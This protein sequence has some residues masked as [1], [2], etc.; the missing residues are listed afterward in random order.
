MKI[1]GMVAAL[2]ITAMSIS[3]LAACGSGDNQSQEKPETL[4]VWT[5]ESPTSAQY[6]AWKKAAE[7]FTKETG[8][9]TKFET[10]SFTQ[11]AQNSSQFLD[12]DQAPDVMESNRGNGSAGMLSSMG[13]L[14]DLGPYVK[15]YGW[16]KKVTQADSSMA[17]YDDKGIMDGN[18][19][20]GLPSYAE[21]QRVYYN[22]DMFA[23]YGV[24][25]PTTMD[26]FEQACQKFKDAGVTPID[27][28]AG[29]YG[30]LWLWWQLVSTKA[31]KQFMADWQMYK[32]DVNW[33]S[34]P[35]TYA[36]NTINEWLEKGY[37]SRNATGL[38]AEDTNSSFIKGDY[39]MYQTGTWNQSRFISQVK[40]FDWEAHILPGSK[41]AQGCTGNLMVIPEKSK[42]KDYAAQ[43][44]DKIISDGIQKGIAEEGGIPVSSKVKTS[45]NEKNQAMIEEYASFSKK[46]A[47]SY[48]PDYPAA[49]LTDAIPAALQELVNGTKNPDQV[50]SSIKDAYTSGVKDMDVKN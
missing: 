14:S 5:Y 21:F 15:K 27:A 44:L 35:L 10:K 38:K 37:I 33:K 46:D 12:S 50:L 45:S 3:T 40:T 25:I 9:K 4:S 29:E 13:L 30:V 39:P 28:D 18:T 17:R 41:L 31:D 34:E 16:D 47:L 49:N 8:I 42:H 26:E 6:H 11:I 2:A 23:K 43:L 24:E 36:T 19:W 22:K 1:K 32:H 20:Y 48:Y 7:E